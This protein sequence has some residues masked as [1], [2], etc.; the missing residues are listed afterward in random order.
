MVTLTDVKPPTVTITDPTR[1]K[2][3]TTDLPTI[4][5]AG[6][7]MD[8]VT[9]TDV[10]WATDTGTN[11]G[12]CVGTTSWKTPDITLVRGINN[13]T[14]TASDSSALATS[15]VLKVTYIPPDV[16]PPVVIIDNPT[17]DPKTSTDAATITIGGTAVDDTSIKTLTWSAD[18][19]GKGTVKAGSKFNISGIKLTLGITNITVT[20]TDPVGN[21]ASDSIEVTLLDIKP[22]T[23]KI[24]SPSSSGTYNSVRGTVN[25]GGSASDNIGIA[26]VGWSTSRG[27][28][29]KCTGTAAWKAT[30]IGV[31]PG[32]TT[33]TVT[34]IDG[35]GNSGS[36][37][38][39]VMYAPADR[40][41]PTIAITAP[42]NTAKYVTAIPELKLEGI[43]SDDNKVTQIYWSNDRG[44]AGKATGTSEWMC[45][46][47]PL[48]PGVNVITATAEDGA[49]NRTAA[50]LRVTLTDAVAVQITS[51]AD[52]GY[53]KWI[54]NQLIMSG[55]AASAKGISKVSWSS[56]SGS[57]GMCTGTNVWSAVVPMFAGTNTI[58]VT[59]L[60]TDNTTS[61]DVIKVDKVESGPGKSWVGLSMVSLPL[62]PAYTDPK[63]SVG[64]QDSKW[65]CYNTGEG[66]YYSYPDLLSWFIPQ[67]AV[68]GRGWWTVFAATP[69]TPL[70]RLAPQDTAAEIKLYPGW[71]MFGM[72]FIKNIKWDLLKLKVRDLDKKELTLAASTKLVAPYA[73]GWQQNT[74]NPLTGAYFIVSDPSIAV[75]DRDILEPWRAYWIHATEE[76]TLIISP[77][78]AK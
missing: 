26:E 58:T 20:A 4:S 49:G 1:G 75:V 39:K 29:G 10:K 55:N 2:E 21:A 28:S 31:S 61:T 60:G 23:V 76:C 64:F 45:E 67:D 56:S 72:P 65:T 47:I 7:A 8:N 71:N 17:M 78:G 16:T 13:I 66:R 27:E 36:T 77:G 15:A 53:C 32:E 6:T 41:A 3:Y 73:W 18:N 9:V 35:G 63:I 5:L 22:P 42:T 24:T 38:M 19:G 70:G 34:A 51:P 25:L 14:I 44:V 46:K 48:L 74:A 52:D 50:Q 57:S 37:T 54:G 62:I 43:A 69:A 30:S 11:R 33:I 12:M 68:Q 59:A 40:T